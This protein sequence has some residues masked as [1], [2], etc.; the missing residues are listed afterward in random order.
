MHPEL[1]QW[2]VK[3]SQIRCPAGAGRPSASAKLQGG[4]VAH[5]VR[6]F[7]SPGLNAALDA[8]LAR[9]MRAEL[10]RVK[11]LE[12]TEA[13][14]RRASRRR[15]RGWDRR[16]E[17]EGEGGGGEGDALAKALGGDEG[18]GEKSRGGGGG[19]AESRAGGERRGGGGWRTEYDIRRGRRRR[20]FEGPPRGGFYDC[21]RR[22]AA[23]S[24]NF[25]QIAAWRSCSSR[26]P[27]TSSSSATMGFPR[28]ELDDFR[29]GLRRHLP[30][31][32]GPVRLPDAPATS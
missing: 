17:S 23:K 29:R 3:I 10:D 4:C 27:P 21:A 12:A 15:R 11:A 9:R 13:E 32:D 24:H 7:E 31:G 20:R 16:D 2:F 8:E 30:R 18:G 28:H 1:R 6:E 19:G 26:S 22:F 25:S 14:L 5:C